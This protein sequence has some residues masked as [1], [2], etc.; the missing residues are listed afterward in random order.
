MIKIEQNGSNFELVAYHPVH[1]TRWVWKSYCNKE[2]AEK[3][4]VK[5]KDDIEKNH[6]SRIAFN[7]AVLETAK[8]MNEYYDNR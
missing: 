7:N 1:N 5:N 4:L 6:N 8:Q 2:F 3:G